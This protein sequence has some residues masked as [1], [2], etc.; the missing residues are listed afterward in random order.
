M[1]CRHSI[2][3]KV[4]APPLPELFYIHFIAPEFFDVLLISWFQC[5]IYNSTFTI[6]S[7]LAAVSSKHPN[8]PNPGKE[9]GWTILEQEISPLSSYRK[10][11]IGCL[12]CVNIL[13]SLMSY[14]AITWYFD[15]RCW[16][17]VIL[18]SCC[19]MLKEKILIKCWQILT[20]MLTY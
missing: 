5:L 6:E 11:S 13:L 9:T 18:I 2:L 17:S 20:K 14:L 8:S 7:Y 4:F 16:S 19:Q 15:L 10:R 3:P 12:C 1:P